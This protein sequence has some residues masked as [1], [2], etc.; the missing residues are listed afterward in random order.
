MS[1]IIVPFFDPAILTAPVSKLIGSCVVYGAVVARPALLHG[2]RLIPVSIIV[3]TL[4]FLS[5]EC[6]CL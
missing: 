1:Q 4:L 2:L 5:V 6:A 3:I